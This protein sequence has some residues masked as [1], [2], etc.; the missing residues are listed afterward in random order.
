MIRSTRIG[1]GV[2]ATVE[3]AEQGANVIFRK[4]ADK[5]KQ[6]PRVIESVWRPPII[7]ILETPRDRF[8]RERRHRRRAVNRT[9]NAVAKQSRKV[10]R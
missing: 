2:T 8:L 10:N 4:R 9:R 5:R 6:E 7:S 3:L 1:G